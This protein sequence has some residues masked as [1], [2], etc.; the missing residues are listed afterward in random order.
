[1]LDSSLISKAF[2]WK[3]NANHFHCIAEFTDC[4]SSSTGLCHLLLHTESRTCGGC[5]SLGA[6]VCAAR[7]TLG[8]LL[9]LLRLSAGVGGI[10]RLHLGWTFLGTDLGSLS[11]FASMSDELV[12]RRPSHRVGRTTRPSRMRRPFARGACLRRGC[13]GHQSVAERRGSD[14][15]RRNREHCFSVAP[16]CFGDDSSSCFRACLEWRC[17]PRAAPPHQ[18]V[19]RWPATCRPSG[20]QRAWRRP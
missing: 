12:G 6:Q 7:L 19:G 1:M 17:L 16:R 20:G 8:L 2:Y 5:S 14:L 11:G 3:E 18:S 4:G 13:C 9:P 15:G 10:G